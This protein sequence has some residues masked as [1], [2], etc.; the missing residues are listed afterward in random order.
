MKSRFLITTAVKRTWESD[1]PVLFLGE[2][3]RLYDCRKDWDTLDAEVV[4]YHWN[5][6]KKLYR[7]YL[8]LR[9]LYEELLSDLGEVLNSFHGTNH[10]QRYWRILT[11]PWLSYFVEILFD[12]WSMIQYATQHYDI[13]STIVL[14]VPPDQII[15]FDMDPFGNYFVDDF[16]NHAIYGII[17]K[18]WTSIAC[19][20]S[21]WEPPQLSDRSAA[22][23]DRLTLYRRIRRFVFNS[24]STVSPLLSRPHDSFF[25]NSYMPL[26]EQWKLQLSLGQLPT[27]WR[28]RPSPQIPA[29]LQARETIMLPKTNNS[30]FESFARELIPYQ[31]PTAYLEGYKEVQNNVSKLSWPKQPKFVMTAVS[32]VADEVFKCYAANLVERGCPLVIMVHGGGGTFAY[33]SFQEIDIDVSDLYLTWGWD[34]GNPKVLP[35]VISKTI[36]KQRS[37]QDPRGGMLLVSYNS[38]RYSYRLAAQ[39]TYDQRLNGYQTDQFRF[40]KAL[41]ESLQNRV[42]VRLYYDYGNCQKARWQDNCPQVELAPFS[43]PYEPLLR[44]N[45]LFIATYNGTTF[46]ESLSRDIPTIMFWNPEHWE[47]QPSAQPSFDRL[48]AV[49]IFHETPESAAAKVA[50]VWDDVPGWWNQPEVQEAREYFCHRF[51]RTVENPIQVLKEALSTVVSWNA[52]TA[53]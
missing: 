21:P 22:N 39:P 17:L 8:Y 15:P 29:N 36:G 42:V 35:S 50:E 27:W 48:K 47:L 32:H 3:C 37:V 4:P 19:E 41:P 5:D 2:W 34:S 10:S 25:I 23:P 1:Q 51:A 12:R 24:I 45:R 31:I 40:V 38:S 7:D 9:E 14:D 26:K 20:T 11:G 46:L 18:D 16:W 49:G 53:T 44:K 6:R 28:S 30:Q 52:G 13:S 33:S 43:L